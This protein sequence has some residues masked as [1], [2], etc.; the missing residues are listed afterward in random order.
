MDWFFGYSAIIESWTKAVFYSAI[1][2]FLVFSGK[3]QNI[4]WLAVLM[5]LFV[6][7]DSLAMMVL[8]NYP[9]PVE[10]GWIGRVYNIIANVFLIKLIF[11]RPFIAARISEFVSRR[12]A[13]IAYF[14]GCAQW[15]LPAVG[16]YHF[17]KQE[18]VLIKVIKMA[19]VAQALMIAHYVLY[20]LGATAPD[21]PLVSVGLDRLVVFQLGYAVLLL[22]FIAEVVVLVYLII[23]VVARRLALLGDEF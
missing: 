14:G 7:V 11:E 20:F 19:C 23:E 5:F 4:R 1:F 12:F 16:T 6:V 10:H 8:R 22:S 18:I 9:P 15:L 17:Y 21:G 13:H 2:L 3:N